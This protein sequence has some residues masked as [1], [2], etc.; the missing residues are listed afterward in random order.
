MM[1]RKKEMGL[2]RW[3]RVLPNTKHRIDFENQ[4]LAV[5]AEF[6]P[7]DARRVLDGHKPSDEYWHWLADQWEKSG[8]PS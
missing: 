3:A 7:E 2:E 6:L 1:T 4:V 8:E 5:G